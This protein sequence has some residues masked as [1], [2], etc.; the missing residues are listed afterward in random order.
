MRL[1][2]SI[3]LVLCPLL[4]A[5]DAVAQDAVTLEDLLEEQ[6][7]EI[8][9]WIEPEQEIVMSQRVQLKIEV[10]TKKWFTGGTRI[11]R[12]EIRDAM[13]LQPKGLATNFTRRVGADTWSVQEWTIN[14]FPQQE[15]LF[16]IPALPVTLSISGPDNKPVTGTVNIEPIRFQAIVPTELKGRKGW[17][18]T[19]QFEVDESFD[20]SVEDLK[21]GDSL[22]RTVRFRAENIAAMMLPEM[23]TKN[24]DG[25]GV[26]RKSPLVRDDTNRGALV[27]ERTETLTYVVERAGTY[28]LPEQTFYWWNL[29]TGIVETVILPERTIST[30]NAPLKDK[31]VSDKK[32]DTST[33]SQIDW[34]PFLEWMTYAALVSFLAWR[35][36]RLIGRWRQQRE[37]TEL[38]PPSEAELRAAF[39]KACR[40]EDP[41]KA[42]AALYRWLDRNTGKTYEGSIRIYLKKLEADNVRDHFDQEMSGLYSKSASEASSV[43][44]VGE[45][46]I[47]MMRSRKARWQKGKRELTFD[48]N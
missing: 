3:V 43:S 5:L 29:A 35:L 13:V 8:R 20:K 37:K 46:L 40:Q 45:H 9:S 22:G 10:S 24:L 27:G 38:Q 25:L 21:P 15:G 28:I 47:A 12:L 30:I 42:L 31:D 18:A 17:V 6:K 23:T 16:E 34:R 33:F 4:F 48:L 26:Y 7:L 41:E 36:F 44:E 32:S 2:N 19:T 1:L 11:G 39:H 14:I